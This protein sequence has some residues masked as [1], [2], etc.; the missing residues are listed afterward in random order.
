MTFHQ[1]GSAQPRSTRLVGPS[2]GT[3]AR[4]DSIPHTSRPPD[5]LSE[6]QPHWPRKEFALSRLRQNQQHFRA[7]SGCTSPVVGF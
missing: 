6:P 3:G 5:G 2:I 4:A 7:V 1:L